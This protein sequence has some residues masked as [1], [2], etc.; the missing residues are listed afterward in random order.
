MR[1]AKQKESVPPPSRLRSAW[2][3]LTGDAPTK[4]PAP[5]RGYRKELPPRRKC[6]SFELEHEGYRWTAQIG[7][8]PDGAVGEVFLASN[9]PGS[10]IEVLVQDAC[11]AASIALQYGA[12]VTVVA[13]SFARDSRDNPQS[14]IGVVMDR[15][16]AEPASS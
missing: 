15:I 14:P 7:R 2:R 12:P 6:E 5:K 13:K 10:K 8:Y 4:P 9:K 16:I 3:A 1:E 11:V